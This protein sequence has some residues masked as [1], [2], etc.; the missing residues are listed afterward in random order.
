MHPNSKI[1]DARQGAKCNGRRRAAHQT[2]YDF[3]IDGRRIECKSSLVRWDNCNQCWFTSFTGVKLPLTGVR[4]H[5]PFDDL[6][7]IL[8]SPDRVDIIKHDLETR[9]SHCGKET[10]FCGYQIK[11]WGSKGEVCWKAARRQILDKLLL[12]GERGCSLRAR[13]DLSNPALQSWLSQSL[14][15]TVLPQDEAYFD[16]PL[17]SMT[18]SVRGL[19][20]EQIAL[21]IDKILH[22]GC[23]FSVGHSR[24]DWERGGL[25][26]EVK[27]AQ[28]LFHKGEGCW[29][30]AFW[31]IKCALHGARECDA[32]DELWL[33]VYSPFGLHFFK[34]PGGTV[35]Y[36]ESGQR[37]DAQGHCIF[38]RAPAGVLD[39]RAALEAIIQN[40][41]AKGCHFFAEVEWD[42]GRSP[43]LAHVK[44]SLELRTPEQE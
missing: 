31:G 4:E 44:Q 26:I 2:E 28:M 16:T 32:F 37:M 40:M 22:P 33:A 38:F 39:V 20:I 14:R 21:E 30:C 42:A 5:A 1:Q 13:I 9:I 3:S 17:N 18:S 6:Y 23:A 43:S 29:M 36:V 15:T 34:H 27:H 24:I 12:D 11:V 7:L 19:R 25:G 8:L 41:T 35:G 10:Q